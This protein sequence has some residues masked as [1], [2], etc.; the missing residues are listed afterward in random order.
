M[1][2]LVDSPTAFRIQPMQIDTKNRH[3]NGT[4][5]KPDL[6]PKA[7]AAPPNAS[8]SGLLECPCTTR[9]KKVVNITYAAQNQG[10]CGT[11]VDRPTE[12]FK[13][14]VKLYP[15]LANQQISVVD[16]TDYPTGCSVIHHSTDGKTEVIL[17]KHSDG[18]ACGSGGNGQW[19]GESSSTSTQ[20]NFNLN[21]DKNS[22]KATLN[23]S[24][25]VIVFK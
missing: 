1:A 13:A 25:I 7:S 8:Y 22:D 23:I 15:D 16:S 18:P 4:D 24:G 5:F 9:I 2:Q 19:F 3:Y 21:M 12:C 6:L 14:A 17:N 11:V 20:V 10:T